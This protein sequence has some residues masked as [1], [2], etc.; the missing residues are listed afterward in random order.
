MLKYISHHCPSVYKGKISFIDSKLCP[1]YQEIIERD[2]KELIASLQT[3]SWKS[4]LMLVGS[5][6]EGL[7]YC[8]LKKN[9]AN[10]G[11]NAGIKN[12][13]I[14]SDGS[15]QHYLNVFR[16]YCGLFSLDY[17][18]DFIS[19]YRDIIHPNFELN[20]ERSISVSEDTVKQATFLLNK[21]IED[22]EHTIENIFELEEKAEDL[23]RKKLKRLG[24]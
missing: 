2:L 14:M 11:F 5:M 6:L 19:C 16:R 18:P 17:F 21:A 12:F 22:F 9:E 13:E 10:I 4:A 7:L 8:F 24:K 23:R 3:K 15:L 1:G 20:L